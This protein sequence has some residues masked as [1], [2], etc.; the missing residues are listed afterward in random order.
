MGADPRFRLLIA[1][2]FGESVGTGPE[3]GDE[4]RHLTDGGRVAAIDEDHG[5][6]PV[7]EGSLAGDVM[8]LLISPALVDR[9]VTAV[10]V[11]VGVSGVE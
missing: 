6:G 3:H 11:T 4:Q 7:D 10:T 9:T 1:R 5:P 2:D 8:F